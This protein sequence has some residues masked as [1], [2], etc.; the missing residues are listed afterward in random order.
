LTQP[1]YRSDRMPVAGRFRAA[2]SGAR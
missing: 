2:A 1:A